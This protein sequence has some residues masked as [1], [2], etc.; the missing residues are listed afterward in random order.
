M[1]Q[2]TNFY[3]SQHKERIGSSPVRWLSPHPHGR[4]FFLCVI[5]AAQKDQSFI[6][7][8]RKYELRVAEPFILCRTLVLIM[9]AAYYI[10]SPGTCNGNLIILHNIYSS[11]PYCRHPLK[12]VCVYVIILKD[13]SNFLLPTPQQTH[14]KRLENDLPVHPEAALLDILHV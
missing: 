3:F 5:S 8:V 11:N 1:F 4:D 12:S 6:L 14:L 2:L 10:S 7:R 9:T 13:A